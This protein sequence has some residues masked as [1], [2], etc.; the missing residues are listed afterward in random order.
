MPK[1]KQKK[2]S[3]AG[4]KCLKSYFSVL[5]LQLIQK[6]DQYSLTLFYMGFLVL[7]PAWGQ[8]RVG[9]GKTKKTHPFTLHIGKC[10]SIVLDLKFATKIKT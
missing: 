1:E 7:V 6:S 10:A 8:G 4:V 5:S 2:R 9:R 3:S